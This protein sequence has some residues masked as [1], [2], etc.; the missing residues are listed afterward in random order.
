MGR[1]IKEINSF[2]EEP[3]R[4]FDEEQKLSKEIEDKIN[5]AIL[6]ENTVYLLQNC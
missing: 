3:Q 1:I 4:I 6:H 2:K 5:T